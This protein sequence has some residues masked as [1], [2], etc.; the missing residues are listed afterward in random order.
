MSF[1]YCNIPLEHFPHFTIQLTCVDYW[2]FI[3]ACFNILIKSWR[4]L[5]NSSLLL[6]MRRKFND[7]SPREFSIVLLDSDLLLHYFRLMSGHIIFCPIT[8]RKLDNSVNTTVNSSTLQRRESQRTNAKIVLIWNSRNYINNFPKVDTETTKQIFIFTLLQFSPMLRQYL[9]F[10][11]NVRFILFCRI[12]NFLCY[13]F[14]SSFN[15]ISRCI[16]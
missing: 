16:Q 11:R 5:V 8:N 3:C 4:K 12:L 2:S 13:F 6:K 7:V 14:L 1:H 9:F 10:V 15:Y